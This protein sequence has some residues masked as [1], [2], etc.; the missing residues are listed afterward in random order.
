MDTEEELYNETAIWYA[1][2][3]NLKSYVL[4]FKRL[5]SKMR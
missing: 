2:Y 5:P 3:D 4:S 1:N